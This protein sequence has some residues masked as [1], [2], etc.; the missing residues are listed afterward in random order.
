MDK[1][2]FV[3]CIGCPAIGWRHYGPFDNKPTADRW[4]SKYAN[5]AWR[6]MVN[7]LREDI[8]VLNVARVAAGKMEHSLPAESYRNRT[9]SKVRK[10]YTDVD[11]G[12]ESKIVH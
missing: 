2:L 12:K 11:G 7:R 9:D 10:L 5:A 6:S 3:V 4:A 8:T 1:E